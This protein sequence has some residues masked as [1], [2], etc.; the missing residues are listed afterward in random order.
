MPITFLL[1]ALALQS[2]PAPGMARWTPVAA[3]GVAGVAVDPRSISRAGNRATLIIR[4]RIEDLNGMVTAVM[5][6]RYDC[7]ANTVTREAG[8]MYD[9]AGAFLGAAG[10]GAASQPIPA[11]SLQATLRDMACGPR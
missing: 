8:E 1:A 9:P 4:T 11:A 10:A 3:E 2:M 7:A 5:R 6:Y